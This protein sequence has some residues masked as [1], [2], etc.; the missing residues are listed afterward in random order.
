MNDHLSEFKEGQWW[1]SELDMASVTGSDDFKR[2]VAVVH[3]ML[4]SAA[5]LLEKQSVEVAGSERVRPTPLPP[6]PKNQHAIEVPRFGWVAVKAVRA[7]ERAHG[8]GE[9]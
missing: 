5:D 2:A 8:I 9:A 1:V 6:D 7:I 3:H 4:R